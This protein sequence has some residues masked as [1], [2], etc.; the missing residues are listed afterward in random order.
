MPNTGQFATELLATADASE[1]AVLTG[2]VGDVFID[3]DERRALRLPEFAAITHSGA[4]RA[5]IGYTL[6]RGAFTLTPAGSAA[7]DVYL[8]DRQTGMAEAIAT[9]VAAIT[10][11][12]TPVA[13]IIDHADLLAPRTPTAVTPTVEQAVVLETLQRAA[14]DPACHSRGHAL[15]L[16]ARSGEIHRG[17]VEASGFRIVTAP[18]PGPDDLRVTLELIGE[19]ASTQPDR[20]AR[21]ATDV[22]IDEAAKAL[23]GLRNDDVVGAS[24][25]AAADGRVLTLEDLTDRKAKTIERLGRGTLRLRP[26]GVSLDDVAGLGHVKRYVTERVRSGTF[27]LSI[28]LAGPPGTGKSFSVRGIAGALGRPLV[29]LAEIRSPWVGESESNMA[30]ALDLIDGLAPIVV[31]IDEVDQAIGQRGSGRSSDGGTSERLLASLWEF[32]GEGVTRPSVLF[33]LTTNRLDLLD[34]AQRSRVEVIPILHPTPNEVEQLLHVLAAQLGRRLADDVDV[35][36]AAGHAKLRMTSARHLLRI[37]GC[38][39]TIESLAA[40]GADAPITAGSLRAAIEDYMPQTND[41]EEE[42]MALATLSR[43]SFESLLPWST[44]DAATPG[45][46]P[47]YVRP[48]IG[49]DGKLD[50]ERLRKRCDDLR[51]QLY[52]DFAA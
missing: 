10:E 27:P 18:L 11:C 25:Q 51:L 38:A 42:L 33:C 23:R 40:N 31:H 19:R 5:A 45:D 16:I 3:A 17:V 26:S 32:T 39:V 41:D 46:M 12:E 1:V 21:L 13:L 28:L 49:T 20:F 30:H 43:V 35:P 29:S 44:G 15:V 37:L 50:Q 7:P 14:V 47:F 22:N 6:G 52:G 36:A 48:L 2:N 34:A 8:P 24:R 9:L 4:G